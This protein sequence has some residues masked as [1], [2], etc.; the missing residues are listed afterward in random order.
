MLTY[1]PRCGVCSWRG[2]EDVCPRCGTV[3]LRGLV[4]CRRCGKVFD[5]PLARCDAC[6]GDVD[7]PPTPR[8]TEAA[9]RLA[10]LPGV[11]EATARRLAARGFTDP[12]DV[13]KL[14][15]PDRAVRLGLHRTLA[16]RLAIGTLPEARR[17]RKTVACPT[18]GAI[19]DA[20]VTA[21][22]ACGRRGEGA[23]PEEL[24]RA[25]EQVA[26]FV[27]DL[28]GDPDFRGMP[29]EAREEILDAF[30]EAGLA[31]ADHEYTDQL[32]VWEERGFEVAELERILREEGVEAFRAKFVRLIR[33]QMM[34]RHEGRRFTCPLC[35]AELAATVEECENCGARFR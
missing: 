32:R 24:R 34:K 23:G 26:G 21:C 16:R 29:P 19:R 3:L 6:G 2:Q 11:D 5:G 13:L 12:A 1:A 22:P 17:I 35:D 7:S 25:L 8:A 30:E 27:Y 28:A 15:L 14:A 18:C 10:V 33:A 9:R 31:T 4:L 20:G